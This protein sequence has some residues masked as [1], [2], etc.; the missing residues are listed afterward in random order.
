MKAA[1]AVLIVVTLIAAGLATYRF[2]PRDNWEHSNRQAFLAK[3][4]DALDLA[5]SNNAT[6]LDAKYLEI[7]AFV[8]GRELTSDD[9]R[10]ALQR[11][12]DARSIVDNAAKQKADEIERLAETQR[13]LDEN[14]KRQEAAEATKRQ[15]E[16][17]RQQQ[18]A[19][20]QLQAAR[21]KR[22]L[23]EEAQRKAEE[24]KQ[25]EDAAARQRA[26]E[27]QQ[28]QAEASQ[29]QE[30]AQKQQEEEQQ[31]LAEQERLAEQQRLADA[32]KEELEQRRQEE[33]TAV[34]TA[35]NRVT[36]ALNQVRTDGTAAENTKA[37]LVA[38]YNAQQDTVEN[39]YAEMKKEAGRRYG[40][41]LPRHPTYIPDLPNMAPVVIGRG[42]QQ[43]PPSPPYN[44]MMYN[45]QL[46][47]YNDLLAAAKQRHTDR[48]TAAEQW[49]ADE[50][51][52]IDNKFQPQAADINA[53]ISQLYTQMQSLI[54]QQKQLQQRAKQI[55]AM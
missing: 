2:W 10:G 51:Q 8:G 50:K 53:R 17:Q 48:L 55:G 32:Q 33:K 21:E 54:Q 4:Q 41:E 12:Q 44:Q 3:C 25:R 40:A 27:E 11:V 29:R 38:Q 37:N 6:A 31:R 20:A 19:V 43:P 9:L 26:E 22:R 30:E 52:K 1:L 39:Q 16:T 36:A 18:E 5:K 23:D 45:Q 13:L 28:R 49:R 24:Q 47:Q 46:L 42:R 14:K 35:L 7:L 15:A 34:I